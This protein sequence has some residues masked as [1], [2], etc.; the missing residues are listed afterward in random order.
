VLAAVHLYDQ[1]DCPDTEVDNV[2]A[3]R[4]L[5]LELQPKQLFATQPEPQPALRVGHLR[6]Q[7]AGQRF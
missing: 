7:A 6:P 1:S 2:F 5:A 3:D 4:L